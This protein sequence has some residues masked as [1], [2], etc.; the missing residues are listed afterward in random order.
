MHME[1]A[2][3]MTMGN[4]RR[5]RRRRSHV[6]EQ[7]KTWGGGGSSY[8]QE[9]PVFGVTQRVGPVRLVHG[10]VPQE[11]I[12]GVLRDNRPTVKVD[13]TLPFGVKLHLNPVSSVA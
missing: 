1:N 13:S 2:T 9:L 5:K 8:R 12:D 4:W 7:T 3:T 6:E 11:Q 10:V